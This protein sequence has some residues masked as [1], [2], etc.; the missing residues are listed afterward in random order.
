LIPAF[1]ALVVIEN[2]FSGVENRA[3]AHSVFGVNVDALKRL[4][5]LK[6]PSCPGFAIVAAGSR[7]GSVAAVPPIPFA[8]GDVVTVSPVMTVVPGWALTIRGSVSVASSKETIE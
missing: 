3:G 6:S 5:R 4:S 7:E 2:P 8:L 1:I